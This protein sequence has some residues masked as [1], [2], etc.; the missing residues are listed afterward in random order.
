MLEDRRI[1][2]K[3]L[4]VSFMK[5]TTNIGEKYY[6]ELNSLHHEFNLKI[7]QEGRRRVAS[8]FDYIKK[9]KNPFDPK[10]STKVINIY[11][12]EEVSNSDYLL[13][14]ISVGEKLYN[15]H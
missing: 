11:T 3:D 7:S 4:H 12:Q 5:D 10:G 2:E 9:I 15:G 14:C 1:H 8:L 6:C 13:R